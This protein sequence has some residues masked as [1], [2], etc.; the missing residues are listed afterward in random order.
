MPINPQKMSKTVLFIP[1]SLS[2]RQQLMTS[3]KAKSILGRKLDHLVISK[4]LAMFCI[5]Y[6]REDPKYVENAYIHTAHPEY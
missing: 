1:Q 4:T 6:A 3:S 2:E 5:D